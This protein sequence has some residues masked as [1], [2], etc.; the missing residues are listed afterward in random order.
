[1]RMTKEYYRKGIGTHFLTFLAIKHT[2]MI[3]VSMCRIH[4]VR[5]VM[6]NIAQIGGA[7][8]DNGTTEGSLG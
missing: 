5:T 8:W 2:L 4:F 6:V 3:Q 7:L 1:M